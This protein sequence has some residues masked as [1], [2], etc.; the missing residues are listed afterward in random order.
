MHIDDDHLY[1]GAALTQ[2]A[3][4]QAFTA[5][6]AFK[7]ATKISRSAFRVNDDI[8]VY[9]KYATKSKP[10]Y[11]EFVFTFSTENLDEVHRIADLVPNKTYLSLVCVS[12]RHICCLQYHQ[13]VM[14][15]KRRK[16][17][18]GYDEDQ[19]TILVT[20]DEGKSFRAYVNKS[21][22]KK[23]VLGKPIVI[24]R[25]KFPNQLFE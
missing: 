17:D 16:K 10:P 4:H 14:L 25:N 22:K 23:T 2:I 7:D 3:E 19:Y 18:V 5:I 11:G 12:A 6:N 1:H 24:P 13:L 20:L 21:G 8:A 15:L 9:F